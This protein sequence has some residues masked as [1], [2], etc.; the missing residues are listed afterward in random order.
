MLPAAGNIDEDCGKPRQRTGPTRWWFAD[1]GKLAAKR[2]FLHF[3][4]LG[5]NREL[6]T[7]SMME[8]D[9]NL[10]DVSDKVVKVPAVPIGFDPKAFNLPFH[11][12]IEL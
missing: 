5:C 3:I 4:W 6:Y 2:G 12:G 8:N 11:R 9:K 10:Q 1:L 7:F